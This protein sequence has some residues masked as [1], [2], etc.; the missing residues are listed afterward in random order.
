M[1]RAVGLQAIKEGLAKLDPAEMEK[2]IAANIW[3][4]VYKPYE[5]LD[6]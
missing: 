1:A 4:P 6:T 2:E 3:E 5:H